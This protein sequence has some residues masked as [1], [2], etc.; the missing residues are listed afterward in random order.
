MVLSLAGRGGEVTPRQMVAMR[1]PRRTIGQLK[2]LA[3]RYG[4]QANAVIE[5][6]DER[7]GCAVCG[8]VDMD[9]LVWNEDTDLVTCAKCGATYNPLEG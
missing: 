5:L 3:Q 7:F 9:T 1:L 2:M 6:V 4:S 8:N